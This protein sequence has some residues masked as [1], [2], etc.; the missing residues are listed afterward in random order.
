[1]IIRHSNKKRSCTAGPDV[2]LLVS[3]QTWKQLCKRLSVVWTAP[4][5]KFNELQS[6]MYAVQIAADDAN[7][8]LQ[9][10]IEAARVMM[11]I[12]ECER[13]HHLRVQEKTQQYNRQVV[14]NLKD[15]LKVTRA[16]ANSY[17]SMISKLRILRRKDKLKKS[18]DCSNWPLAKQTTH[19]Q[20]LVTGLQ[21]DA[22]KAIEA[23][24]EHKEAANELRRENARLLSELNLTPKKMQ[25]AIDVCAKPE[26]VTNCVDKLGKRGQQYDVF[27]IEMGLQ[28]M[29]SALSAPQAVY[30][31]TVF[32]MKTYPD[33]AP[34]VDYR[35]PGESQFKEWG[36]AI[37]EVHSPILFMYPPLLTQ[38][39]SRMADHL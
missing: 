8:K 28:L 27:I 36:E 7:T 25:S 23:A 13:T 22:V 30:A 11:L 5:R 29:S 1:L 37:Y 21:L 39:I 16:K 33:L 17:N 19:V 15:Q 31:L 3:E 10:S 20:R 35:I 34:G 2:W 18:P 38:P 4:T 12:M 9:E 24:D 32:M 26:N 14:A 6:E